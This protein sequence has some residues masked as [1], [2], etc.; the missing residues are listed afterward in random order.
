MDAAGSVIQETSAV[1]DGGTGTDLQVAIT[2]ASAGTPIVITVTDHNLS[3]GMKITIASVGGNTNANGTWYVDKT[4]VDTFALYSDSALTVPV[5]AGPGAYTTG[6]YYTH[7]L[8]ATQC[9]LESLTMEAAAGTKHEIEDLQNGPVVNV[10]I[11]GQLVSR[12]SSHRGVRCSPVASQLI[13]N[14][15][16]EINL[17]SYDVIFNSRIEI[18]CLSLGNRPGAREDAAADPSAAQFLTVFLVFVVE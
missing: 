2:G 15:P 14:P 8:L 13:Y 18:A 1:I 4:G 17:E 6:G 7:G 9:V 16:T 12:A 11:G 10:D 3:D 5:I